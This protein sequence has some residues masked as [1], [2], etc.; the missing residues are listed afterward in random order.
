VK[1]SPSRLPRKFF[2][3]TLNAVRG[4]LFLIE[5]GIALLQLHPKRKL[6]RFLTSFEMT[7]NR[8]G[9]L[10]LLETPPEDDFLVFT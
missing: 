5:E 8:R 7:L 4:L 2:F 3:V 1:R 9:G 10:T 6:R